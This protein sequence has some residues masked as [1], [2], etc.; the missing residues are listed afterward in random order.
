MPLN[1][2]LQRQGN[3]TESMRTVLLD[4]I[5]DI[6]LKFKMFPQTLYIITAIIDRYLAIKGGKKE[7]L[8]LI[9]AAALFIGA[10]YE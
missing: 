10:K 8:Q 4:W 5:I 6:H 2:Y 7:E 1:N 3:L 9:G